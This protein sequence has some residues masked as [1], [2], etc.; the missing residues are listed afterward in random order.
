MI[1]I[2]QM[3]EPVRYKLKPDEGFIPDFADLEAK[4]T[5]RTKAIM[6][7]TPGNPTGGVFDEA[8]VKRL[9]DFA[10]R[11]DLYVI[12]DE[13]YDAIIFEG[14]HISPKAYDT[15][16]R[17][18]S[19]FAVSKKYAMTGWRIG[20]AVAPKPVASLMSKIMV[21]MVGNAPS[22]SQKAAEEAITG[23]QQFVE[24]TRRSYQTR[25]D[26]VYDLF[27]QAGIKAYKPNGA[28]YM[29]VDIADCGMPSEQFAIRMLQEEKVA[30]APGSTFGESSKHMI[31]LSFATEQ[32]VLLEGVKR[33]CSFIARNRVKQTS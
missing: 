23:P 26:L 15:E 29:M 32:T 8:T 6:I 11:H 2:A 5:G 1:L 12:S 24:E 14:S 21:T 19:I 31:R 22:I 28:F 18:I 13:V 30:V 3:N 10:N 4:V 25:R 20:Y 9:I 33:I 7:N 16:G 27:V 17:V